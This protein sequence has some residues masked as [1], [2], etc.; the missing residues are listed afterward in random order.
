MLEY[1]VVFVLAIILAFIADRNRRHRHIVFFSLSTLIAVLSL[2]AGFRDIGVGTDTVI[3]SEKYF[4]IVRKISFD[5]LILSNDDSFRS[6]SYLILNYLAST[7]SNNVWIALLFTELTILIPLYYG[8]YKLSK[9]E[10]VKFSIFTALYVFFFLN[11]SFNIMRQSCAVSFVFLAF[12]YYKERKWLKFVILEF[13]AYHFH[14]TSIIYLL[15]P[16][17]YYLIQKKFVS[18]KI[19]LFGVGVLG[20]FVFLFYYQILYFAL[21]SGMVTDYF[22]ENYGAGGFYSD[23]GSVRLRLG[24]VVLFVFF[25]FNVYLAQKNKMNNDIVALWALCNIMYVSLSLLAL[26]V[27]YLQR[28]NY[29]FL[30]FCVLFSSVLLGN[31]KVS[32]LYKV[33]VYLIVVLFWYYNNI[34]NN[35]G[36]TYPYKSLILNI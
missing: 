19:L 25:S 3:Y 24:N 9:I 27:V 10:T 17:F 14:S 28:L 2:F 20:I 22:M 26:Y 15:I 35:F 1:I 18:V 12:C 29:A 32:L 4:E 36:E 8:I 34:V 31:K 7:F 13:I 33:I 21:E 11:Y 16:L 30:L 23:E 5:E 6:K